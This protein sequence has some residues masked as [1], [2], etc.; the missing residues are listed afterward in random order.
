MNRQQIAGEI[1]V[2]GETW[3][4]KDK[5]KFVIIAHKNEGKYPVQALSEKKSVV[6]F[7]KF[8]HF[9]DDRFPHENDLINRM[10]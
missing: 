5:R 4:T 6:N 10:L 7:T 8:G 1:P 2:T 3:E 9:V